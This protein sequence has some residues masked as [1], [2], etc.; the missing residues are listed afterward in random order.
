MI[1]QVFII[2]KEDLRPLED[3]SIHISRYV[4][5]AKIAHRKFL[6]FEEAGCVQHFNHASSTGTL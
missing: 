5:S 2:C 1:S 3:D 6:G 4:S